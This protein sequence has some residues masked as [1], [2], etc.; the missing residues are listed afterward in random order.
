MREVQ[1]AQPADAILDV[2]L[3]QVDRA[4]EA[5]RS[6][7]CLDFQAIQKLFDVADAEDALEGAGQHLLRAGAVAGQ[8]APVEQGGGGGQIV[9]RQVEQI[10]AHHDLVSDAQ[11][12]IPE[13][14]QERLCDG[15]DLLRFARRNQPDIQIT[16][17]PELVSAVAADRGEPHVLPRAGLDHRALGRFEQRAEQAVEGFC[18]ARGGFEASLRATWPDHGLDGDAMADQV[19]LEFLDETWG[20]TFEQRCSFSGGGRH[21]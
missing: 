8:H 9:L 13:R 21:M 2:R 1:I 5:L 16:V 6:L 3:E 14:V 18:V 15:A 19:G 10:A 4:A 7:M 11:P 12:G 17:I 20:C